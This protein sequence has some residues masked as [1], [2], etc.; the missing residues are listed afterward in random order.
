[1]SLYRNHIFPLAS[2]S[3]QGL[4]SSGPFVFS[5]Q[6]KE[7]FPALRNAVRLRPLIRYIQKD[8]LQPLRLQSHY[9]FV[10]TPPC[11][12]PGLQGNLHQRRHAHNHRARHQDVAGQG[13]Q[14]G[15]V[16]DSQTK[17]VHESAYR[18]VPVIC[19]YDASRITG[20]AC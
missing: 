1:M 20:G 15:N 3:R 10:R 7:M 8:Q 19:L 14:P 12:T 9:R 11:E 5:H 6:D 2:H 4:A 13:E 18:L 17:A 16:E